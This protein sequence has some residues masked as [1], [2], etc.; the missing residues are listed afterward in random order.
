MIIRYL[1]TTFAVLCLAA[2]AFAQQE[3]LGVLS[4]L[5]YDCRSGAD[6]DMIRARAAAIRTGET[7]GA[8]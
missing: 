1:T 2:A 8:G 6:R 4:D 7:G 3:V 5:W